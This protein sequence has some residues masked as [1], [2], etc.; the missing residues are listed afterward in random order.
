MNAGWGIDAGLT[1]VALVLVA[2]HMGQIPAPVARSVDASGEASCTMSSLLRPT[3]LPAASAPP[4]LFVE[5]RRIATPCSVWH[6]GPAVEVYEAPSF[7]YADDPIRQAPGRCDRALEVYLDAWRDDQLLAPFD[8]RRQAA[9]RYV[10]RG[11]DGTAFIHLGW[12]TI[13][14]GELLDEPV[15]VKVQESP[16]S[17]ERRTG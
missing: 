3:P 4:E 8:T 10:H 6:R 13:A 7:A 12:W 16:W 9:V 5:A 11:K 14:A 15:Q 1:T 17:L 2:V